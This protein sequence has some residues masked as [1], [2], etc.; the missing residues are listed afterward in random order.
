MVK[1]ELTVRVWAENRLCQFFSP[2]QAAKLLA[3]KSTGELY[4]TGQNAQ[5]LA[6]KYQQ[7]QSDA[8]ASLNALGLIGEIVSVVEPPGDD[9]DDNDSSLVIDGLND[10][11]Y[12]SHMDELDE[13]DK[14][15]ELVANESSV[16]LE[17]PG[18]ED[19][20][21]EDDDNDIDLTNMTPQGSPSASAA[22]PNEAGLPNGD[23]PPYKASV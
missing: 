10:Q 15:D 5:Q 22:D 17:M 20:E 12:Q 1:H 9:D 16:D 4:R 18:N 14:L 11:D 23:T 13:W 6:E 21:A 2:A 7:Q 19:V 3:Q 8:Q